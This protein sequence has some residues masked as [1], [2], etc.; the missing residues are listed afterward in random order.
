MPSALIFT[1]MVISYYSSCYFFCGVGGGGRKR[2]LVEWRGWAVWLGGPWYGVG[3]AGTALLSK[4]DSQ[5]PG[6]LCGGREGLL[7]TLCAHSL[8][9]GVTVFCG[10]SHVDFHHLAWAFKYDM[11]FGELCPI[12]GSLCWTSSTSPMHSSPTALLTFPSPRFRDY[13]GWDEEG[14]GFFLFVCF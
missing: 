10:P 9:V 12:W 7:G 1:H 8:D 2:G 4:P 13:P 11:C 5:L 3:L 6:S 14:E